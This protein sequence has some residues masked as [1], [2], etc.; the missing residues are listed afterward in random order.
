MRICVI[1]PAAGRSERFGGRDK[2]AEDLGGRPVLLRT[3]EL[4][5][6]RDEVQSILVAAPPD[7]LDEF[8]FKFGDRLAFH[9]VRVVAGGTIARW[10]T[11]HN[12]LAEVAD[13]ITHVAVHDA[14][15]PA[16]SSDLLDRVFEAAR[17]FE[18][19]IPVVEIASTVKRLSR[20]A[21]SATEADPIAAAILGDAGADANPAR[22]VVE[23]I[24]RGGLVEA[25][26][27]QVFTLELLRRAYGQSDLSGATDDASLVERLGEPVRAVEGDPRNLKLTTPADLPLIRSVLGVRP[28]K[29]RPVHKRF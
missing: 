21:E 17:K 28:P 11:I 6:K 10:E 2:L 15:R 24:E 29:D 19:V 4:F 8:K 14:A 20:E 9:G 13:D 25:Q 16:T 5:T 26:T 18:A 12:A 1:I 3:I 23:T 27:P 7:K 22:L